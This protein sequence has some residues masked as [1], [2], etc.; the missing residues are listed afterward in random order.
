MAKQEQITLKPIRVQKGPGYT[1]SD[2][3][4]WYEVYSL[5][6]TIIHPVG[7][8]LS[9]VQVRELLNHNRNL[10]VVIIHNKDL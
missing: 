9:K 1:L 2:I 3:G 8:R 6:N 5:R 4:E 7:V 10:D